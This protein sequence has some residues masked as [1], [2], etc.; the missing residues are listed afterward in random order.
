M[1][2]TDVRPCSACKHCRRAWID[3]G[4]YEFAKCHAPG[5]MKTDTV[6]GK[7]TPNL[8]FCS[9]HRSPP[10]TGWT[11]GPRGQWFEPKDKSTFIR[12]WEVIRP[13]LFKE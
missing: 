1:D 9:V 4:G 10:N 7:P 5:N 8:S 2:N 6:S 12:M 3:F 13:I 11:C